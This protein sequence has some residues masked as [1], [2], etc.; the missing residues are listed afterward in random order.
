VLSLT[1]DALPLRCRGQAAYGEPFG[2]LI[3]GARQRLDR[4]RAGPAWHHTLR[5][6]V[7]ET[8]RS[9][10]EATADEAVSVAAARAGLP[11]LTLEGLRELSA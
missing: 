1:I 9:Y 8:G 6:F 10:S 4:H 7:N 3:P 11:P 2:G 5:V